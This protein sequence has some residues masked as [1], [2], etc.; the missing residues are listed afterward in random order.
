MKNSAPRHP[1]SIAVAVVRDL[2]VPVAVDRHG[3]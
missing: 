1:F 2:T 3:A